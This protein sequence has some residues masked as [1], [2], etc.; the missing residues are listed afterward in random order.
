MPDLKSKIDVLHVAT[1]SGRWAPFC[2]QILDF[3]K[4]D[5]IDLVIDGAR[6][7]G[8]RSPDSPAER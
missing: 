8:L 6:V 4:A 2:R 3:L 7:R 1:S 5:P